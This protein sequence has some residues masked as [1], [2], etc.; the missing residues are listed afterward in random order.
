MKQTKQPRQP[1]SL[2]ALIA[3]THCKGAPMR[4]RRQRRPLEERRRALREE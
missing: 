4:D 1:R 3:I 2:P